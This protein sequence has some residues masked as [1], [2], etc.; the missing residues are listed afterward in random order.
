MNFPEWGS[1]RLAAF[2]Q[3]II[4][5]IVTDESLRDGAAFLP[6]GKLPLADVAGVGVGR[7]DKRLSRRKLALLPCHC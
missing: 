2:F 7:L 3:L 4:S 1:R 5:T 6:A